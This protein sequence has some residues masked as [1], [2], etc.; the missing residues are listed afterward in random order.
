[1]YRQFTSSI[2][3]SYLF[4]ELMLVLPS[5]SWHARS[6]YNA[7]T[8]FKMFKYDHVMNKNPFLSFLFFLQIGLYNALNRLKRLEKKMIDYCL[9][10]EQVTNDQYLNCCILQI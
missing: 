6:A 5:P 4:I 1:M 10:L 2:R 7:G 9:T 8:M 3:M